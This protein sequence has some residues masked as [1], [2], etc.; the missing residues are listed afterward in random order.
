M[1]TTQNLVIF[2]ILILGLILIFRLSCLKKKGKSG[3]LLQLIVFF[4][5]V[6]ISVFGYFLRIYFVSRLGLYFSLALPFFI[7]YVSG[8]EGTS[9]SGPSGPSPSW[10]EDSFEIGVL[11]EP[12]SETETEA[13]SVNPPIPRVAGEE[14]GPS[15][16]AA[17]FHNTSLEASL[18]NRVQ[19]LENENSPF[20]LHKERGEYWAEIKNALDQA[21]DQREY[22][23]LLEFENR[24]LQIRELKHSCYALFRQTL[25]EHPYLLENSPQ[26][27][28][29]HAIFSFFD[30]T[31]EDLDNELPRSSLADK[32]RAEVD[33]YRKVVH[34]IRKHGPHSYYIQKILGHL[35]DKDG[36]F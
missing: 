30:E 6:L 15:G 22:K 29:N 1:T 2:S 16:Q 21:Y 14:A 9:Y 27:N 26:P 7:F 31:L 32:D 25:S 12:F 3:F 8:G 19:I 28:P 5:F 11:L 17:I 36:G 13:T 4:L 18:R 34:D 23:R 24:D 33:I 10:T 20:L 35:D